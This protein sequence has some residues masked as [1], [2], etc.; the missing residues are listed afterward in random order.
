MNEP[1]EKYVDHQGV[2]TEIKKGMQEAGKMQKEP[3]DWS[4]IDWRGALFTG[5]LAVVIAVFCFWL[6]TAT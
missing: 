2:G 4:A 1:L 3:A 5:V 6:I